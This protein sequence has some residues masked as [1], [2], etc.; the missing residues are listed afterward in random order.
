MAEWVQRRVAESAWPSTEEAL[1]RLANSRKV[2]SKEA[3]HK[4]RPVLQQA[5]L[6]DFAGPEVGS[7]T[8][9]QSKAMLAQMSPEQRAA[10]LRGME[11]VQALQTDPLPV[12][13]PQ[14]AEPPSQALAEIQARELARAANDRE[15][16]LARAQNRLTDPTTSV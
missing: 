13:G 5:E 7:F 2:R 4:L 16:A 10:T 8:G 15:A 6:L 3:A 1:L 11:A 12:A 9:A 14:A